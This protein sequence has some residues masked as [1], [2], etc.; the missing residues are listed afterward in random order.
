MEYEQIELIN[1]CQSTINIINGSQEMAGKS[2]RMTLAWTSHY[3]IGNLVYPGVIRIYYCDQRLSFY[4]E[5][6][7]ID[8]YLRSNDFKGLIGSIS[9]D[10]DTNTLSRL[11]TEAIVKLACCN[12]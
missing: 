7:R 6:D 10:C 3:M 12:V 8:L 5:K 4:I 1:V 9:K 2:E 11:V